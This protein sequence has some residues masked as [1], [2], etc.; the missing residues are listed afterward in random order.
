MSPPPGYSAY[1]STP[2][3]YAGP[4]RRIGGVAKGIVVISVVSAVLGVVVLGLQVALRDHAIEL[5]D[6]RIDTDSFKDD[7][8]PYLLAAL[9]ALGVSIALFVLQCIWAYRIASNLR[10][11]RREPQSW[12]PGWGIGAWFLAPCTLNI[13]PYLMLRELW[14]G[15]DP[16]VA[17]G[18]PRWKSVPV[19]M[20]V[21]L[22]FWLGI[23]GTAAG[24]AA[25]TVFAFRSQS[26]DTIAKQL[27]DRLPFTI[28]AGLLSVAGTLAF[29]MMV[30]A[31]SARHMAATKEA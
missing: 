5:R 3:G 31:L 1:A 7:I 2:G 24:I 8:A 16:D 13:V 23:A 21:H 20:L 18:D 25:G 30:R 9:I 6:G 29:V 28:G 10:S 11:L 19:G 26:T 22:W 4:F 15:S 17:P 14:K 27:D 12:K